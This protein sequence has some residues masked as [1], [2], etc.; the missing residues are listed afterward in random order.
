MAGTWRG[1]PV[2]TADVW[3]GGGRNA[4]CTVAVVGLRADLPPT[5]IGDR[6]QPAPGGSRKRGEAQL[7]PDV[8]V[9]STDPQF[10]ARLMSAEL[11][12][13]FRSLN[14]AFDF[15]VSG[16]YV[17]AAARLR[18]GGRLRLL[19][20]SELP[21][22]LEA[23]RGFCL[24]VPPGIWAQYPPMEPDGPGPSFGWGIRPRVAISQIVPTTPWYRRVRL[25]DRVAGAASLAGAVVILVSFLQT[26]VTVP[27]Q[28]GGPR[29][30]IQFAGAGGI[31]LLL[32]I[33][34]PVSAS[35]IYSLAGGRS[36][37]ITRALV[38]GVAGAIWVSRS[39]SFS[40]YVHTW[41]QRFGWPTPPHQVGPG[42]TSGI[43]GGSIVLAGAALL[44]VAAVWFRDAPRIS[45]R[46]LEAT[47]AGVPDTSADRWLAYVPAVFPSAMGAAQPP[48]PKRLP[49]ASS[50]KPFPRLLAVA[51][52]LTSLSITAGVAWHV[53]QRAEDFARYGVEVSAHVV[54][55]H[56]YSDDSGDG[57]DPCDVTVQFTSNLGTTITATL[58]GLD[59][60]VTYEIQGGCCLP[61]LYDSRNPND[62]STTTIEPPAT[63][64]MIAS[65][66]AIVLIL[67]F[68]LP[69]I[70]R[71]PKGPRA[72]PR[73]RKT[74]SATPV[75]PDRATSRREPPG[76]SRRS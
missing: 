10:A 29:N 14:G 1:L 69:M 49:V 34:V 22:L 64:V 61:I 17:V 31:W 5:L 30:G 26:W 57:G 37:R 74:G 48:R 38:T 21:Y 39:I 16:G 46:A 40:A 76:T 59:D 55:Y 2:T 51:L 13:W 52:L 56:C 41:L 66:I 71:T 45:I 3:W 20:P 8:V 50:A 72:K 23:V 35:G 70:R 27:S 68:T 28:F 43:V 6:R 25:V 4:A 12:E 7:W 36:L 62:V 19:R 24:R 32:G 9:S 33:V 42:P 18:R 73:N 53:Y 15:W 11:R 47:G 58:K 67:L 54:H 65:V 60:S 44:V 75:R 63:I